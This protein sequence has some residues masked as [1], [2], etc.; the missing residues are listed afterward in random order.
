MTFEKQ[1]GK[2]GQRRS[3][4]KMIE[5]YSNIL[6]II[7][8]INRLNSPVKKQRSNLLE[9]KF[10]SVLLWSESGYRLDPSLGAALGLC[11][12]VR[13]AHWTWPRSLLAPCLWQLVLQQQGFVVAAATGRPTGCRQ[14]LPGPLPKKGAN[15]WSRARRQ[16]G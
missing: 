3:Q 16:K 15:P 6:V 8:N 2:V 7:I 11:P 5:I 14:L 1:H 4:N 13:E 12:G 9:T 10:S